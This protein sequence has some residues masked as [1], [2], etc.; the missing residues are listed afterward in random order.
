MAKLKRNSKGQFIARGKGKKKGKKRG[1][2]NTPAKA[3]SSAARR[4]ANNAPRKG[5]GQFAKQNFWG[6]GGKKSKSNPAVDWM[7]I[8]GAAAASLGAGI[9]IQTFIRPTMPKLAP[10]AGPALELGLG[11]W[12]HGKAKSRDFGTGML[13]LGVRDA[14]QTVLG[15]I[16]TK[17][18]TA[19]A[20]VAPE[21][22]AWAR[23]PGRFPQAAMSN[24]LVSG[25]QMQRNPARVARA[26]TRVTAP[27]GYAGYSN[28]RM[29]V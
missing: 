7:Q 18:V 28:Q 22:A 20:A 14:L 1:R 3:K 27:S 9:A 26:V 10:F 8:G 19:T 12:A 16:Q 2:R 17:M 6:G 21:G 29:S 4:H 5:N 25:T 23:I 24:P 11:Y 13:A 15:L